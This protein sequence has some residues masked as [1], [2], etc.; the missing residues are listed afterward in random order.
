[1]KSKP[2]DKL[3]IQKLMFD[4]VEDLE[5]R[6]HSGAASRSDCF[7]TADIPRLL[8]LMSRNPITGEAPP[9][10]FLVTLADRIF[11]TY[12]AHDPA[13]GL[14][15]S[16]GFVPFGDQV[17]EDTQVQSYLREVVGC[18]G[19]YMLNL[20]WRERVLPGSCVRNAT[21]ERVKRFERAEGRPA[22]K[23]DWA[24]FKDVVTAELLKSAPVRRTL[25]PI[26][27]KDGYQFTFTS[28]WRKVEVVNAFLRKI[29]GTWM[30]VPAVDATD[31][32]AEM[33]KATADTLSDRDWDERNDYPS[34]EAKMSDGETVVSVRKEDI[35]LQ[36]GYTAKELFDRNHN[37]QELLFWLFDGGA[38]ENEEGDPV[39]QRG[40]DLLFKMNTDGVVKKL[41][42]GNATEDAFDHLADNS[43]AYHPDEDQSKPWLICHALDRLIVHLREFDCIGQED[44]E[45]Y[46]HE[47]YDPIV[48]DGIPVNRAMADPEDLF[49]DENLVPDDLPDDYDPDLDDDEL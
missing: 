33:F 10:S 20:E 25:I 48:E 15:M 29:F 19:A 38:V 39:S 26:I 41:S 24:V 36:H 44:E 23:K 7:P 45:D 9:T 37:F 30:V 27:V 12:R 17:D 32:M 47:V 8:A 6:V 35:R 42:F 2:Y 13:Q 31:N 21:A 5:A 28:S 3:I 43:M 40:F 18:H 14:Y 46:S 34:T 11:N 16:L 49:A 1:M 22:N 4:R